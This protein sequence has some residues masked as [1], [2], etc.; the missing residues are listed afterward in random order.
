MEDY[1]VMN[2]AIFFYYLMS[3]FKEYYMLIVQ[4]LLV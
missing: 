1:S 3:N 4:I 2:S